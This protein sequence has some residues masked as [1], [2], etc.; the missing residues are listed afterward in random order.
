MAKF[1][2]E[3]DRLQTNYALQVARGRVEGAYPYNV[4]GRRV[5]IAPYAGILWPG[6]N[7]AF[8]SSLGTQLTVVST[9]ANDT[10]AGTGARTIRIIYLDLNLEEK[11][12]D[13]VMNGLTP[14]LTVATNIRYVNGAISLTL[15][16]GKAAAGDITIFSGAG[17]HSMIAAGD[18]RCSCS[19]RTVPAGKR[20]IVAAA[21]AGGISG[22]AA[23][24]VETQ[25]A[26]TLYQGIDFAPQGIFIPYR[27]AVWQDGSGGLDVTF[28][29]A[30]PSGASLCTLASCDK[31]A[32]IVGSYQG[33]M[34]PE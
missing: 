15:G 33:I 14:V 12:E 21:Y 5:T 27:A 29:A 1:L 18:V 8:P 17:N 13:V 4:Y 32:T 23:A 28:P 16:S 9:S 26:T 11:Y 25:V 7:F 24:K 3:I 2:Y 34:E 10:A 31:A 22:T 20:F 30:F 19:V 6:S